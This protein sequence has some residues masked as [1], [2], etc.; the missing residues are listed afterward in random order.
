[1]AKRDFVSIGLNGDKDSGYKLTAV[2]HDG[3]AWIANIYPG[4]APEGEPRRGLVVKSWQQ[5]K[6]LPDIEEV[7]IP[8]MKLG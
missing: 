3:T 6:P 5:I 7:P 4:E 8:Q 1:M 2:A